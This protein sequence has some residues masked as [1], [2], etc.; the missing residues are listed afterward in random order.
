MAAQ[1]VEKNDQGL[2]Q[3]TVYTAIGFILDGKKP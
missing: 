2:E 1:H 3:D